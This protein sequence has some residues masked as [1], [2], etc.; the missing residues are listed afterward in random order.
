VLH[1]A[2]LAELRRQLA[3]KTAWRGSTVIQA[4]TFYPS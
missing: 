4:P 2:A 1:D 3:Y